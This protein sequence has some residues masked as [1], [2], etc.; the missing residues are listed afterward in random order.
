ME[1]RL[2]ISLDGGGLRGVWT[3]TILSRLFEKHPSL[4][5]QVELYSGASTGGIIA[6]MLAGGASPQTITDFYVKEGPVIFGRSKL[7]RLNF[8]K[9]YLKPKYN[10][11]KMI[12]IVK[13]IMGEEIAAT[14]KD[15]PT[16]VIVPTFDLY[17]EGRGRW[18][19][20][21]YHN[22]SEDGKWDEECWKLAIKTTAAP[23]FF[24]PF[25]GFIDGGV[26]ANNPSMIAVGRLVS[27]YD[28]SVLD[29][30]V[31]LS[32]G[33]TSTNFKV[34]PPKKWGFIQWALP[35][36]NIFMEGIIGIPDYQCQ[37]LVK[38]YMKVNE[39]IDEEYEFDDPSV[40]DP[41]LKAAEA[42]DLS[43]VEEFLT[44]NKI[45]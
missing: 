37:Q 34:D 13:R 24:A 14:I 18:S 28:R 7:R 25:E 8:I 19:P 23:G 43:P 10:I 22:Y 41:L 30:M 1:K 39:S 45:I 15:L 42:Y 6:I 2:V 3:T 40:I 20:S 12:N 26:V 5:G 11:K 9:G 32:F 38:N 31:L 4:R 35:L 33:T 27:E 36:I 29:D 16:K 44:S 21:F 17:H